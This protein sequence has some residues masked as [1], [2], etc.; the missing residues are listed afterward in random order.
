M[1]FCSDISAP[2]LLPHKQQGHLACSAGTDQTAG[3]ARLDHFQ[4][5]SGNE[6]V[7]VGSQRLPVGRRMSQTSKVPK[8]SG[9]W[10]SVDPELPKG[11]E[12]EEE[13]R[14]GWEE[15]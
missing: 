3:N 14:R 5:A 1:G 9:T 6:C 2:V 15:R 12:M 8:D 7:A 11:K 10:D 4:V 13:E